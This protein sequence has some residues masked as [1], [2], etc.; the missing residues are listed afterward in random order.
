M[1][2]FKV[3]RLSHTAK[4]PERAHSNDTGYD[5]IADRVEE[6]AE[7]IKVYTGIAIQPEPGYWARI[8][9]RSS[10]FKKK[11]I[12]ANSPAT[13][14]EPYTGEIILNFYK[15]NA[16]V[17]IKQGE[18]CAQLEVCE[19]IDAVMVEVPELDETERGDG[20]FGSTGA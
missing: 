6:T 12:L 8:V 2:R 19:R 9:P 10:I 18:K 13:I 5:I 1:I 11:L 3:K 16:S 7:M 15:L 14:D 4:L 17:P 20:G